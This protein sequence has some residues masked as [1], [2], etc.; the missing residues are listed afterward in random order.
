M[1]DDEVG[2]PTLLRNYLT[3]RATRSTPLRAVKPFGSPGRRDRRGPDGSAH[4][5]YGRSGAGREIHA[6]RPETQVAPMTAFGGIDIAVEAIK[7]GADHL[8]AKPVKRPEVGALVRKALT[9]GTR[10]RNRHLRQAVE[11]R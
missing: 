4:G 2:T 1:V 9:D 7:A 11:A 10:A 6:T 8:V 5:W 3:A